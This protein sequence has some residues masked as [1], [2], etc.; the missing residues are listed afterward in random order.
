MT[1]AA[2]E[3]QLLGIVHL[4]HDEMGMTYSAAA[5]VGWKWQKSHS[6]TAFI[7]TSVHAAIEHQIDVYRTQTFTKFSMDIA[8]YPADDATPIVLELPE[9]GAVTVGYRTYIFDPRHNDEPLRSMP[10][11]LLRGSIQVRFCR[12]WQPIAAYLDQ[13][14]TQLNYELPLQLALDRQFSWWKTN[15][16]AF[17]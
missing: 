4:L 16:K 1:L 14:S 15:G 7:S 17:K 2:K 9:V 13:I 3:K 10:V 6:K 5:S 11:R 8:V 12:Q